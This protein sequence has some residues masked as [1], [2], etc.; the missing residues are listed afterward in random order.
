MMYED[1]ILLH[2]RSIY[3]LLLLPVPISVLGVF[4]YLLQSFR[5]TPYILSSMVLE[6]QSDPDCSFFFII[7]MEWDMVT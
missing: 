4:F 2:I 6:L 7:S 5:A 1:M 3:N